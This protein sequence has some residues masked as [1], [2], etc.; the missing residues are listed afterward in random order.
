MASGIVPTQEMAKPQRV[1]I[2]RAVTLDDLEQ[3]L[4]SIVGQEVTIDGTVY[5]YG[6]H[7]PIETL[8]ERYVQYV[9]LK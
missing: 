6:L 9:I 4:N 2:V 7:G 3:Q 1:V 8:S 5:Q